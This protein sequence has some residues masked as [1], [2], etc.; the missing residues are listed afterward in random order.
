MTNQYE[1]VDEEFLIGY[2][3][4]NV[5]TKWI[6][7]AFFFG[8][9][10]AGLFIVS[11]LMGTPIIALIGLIIANVFKGGS[12]LIHLGR[13]E[14]F[15]RALSRPQTS[16]IA[17]TVWA[18]GI[19]TVI[20]LIFLVLPSGTAMWEIFRVLALIGAIIVAITDGF[21]VNDSTAIPLWNT[22]MLPLL[23]LLYSLLGGTTLFIFM[24]AI[25]W[26]TITQP[27]L[28]EAVEIGLIVINLTAVLVYLMSV[29]NS[30]YAA[31]KSLKILIKEQYATAFY[32]L[33]IAV[34]FIATLLLLLFFGTAGG[35]LVVAIITVADLIGHF[36]IFYLLLMS[37]VY[38]TPLG[39]L[40]L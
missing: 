9:I 21:V 24:N 39:T 17:R 32:G 28:F 20:G 4:Q 16:W 35:P 29:T 15:W 34:G 7:L 18:M 6:A 1:L 33:V 40:T 19:F 10:G 5:W 25:G 3:Q 26:L 8:K 36:F 23:F 30:T 14:R 22:S 27:Y 2:R 11:V 12:L 37:G 31:R 38:S 13:P